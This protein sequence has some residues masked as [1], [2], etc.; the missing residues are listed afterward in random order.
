MLAQRMMMSI[1]KG[2]LWTVKYEADALPQNSTPAWSI[3]SGGTVPTASVTGGELTIVSTAGGGWLNY[4]ITQPSIDAT[5]THQ[6]KA[7][8]KVT[9]GSATF[10][11]SLEIDDG[12]RS[13]NLTFRYDGTIQYNNASASPTVLVTGKSFT[14]Y[15]EII[16]EL[17]QANGARVY[18]NGT[19]LGSAAYTDLYAVTTKQA[20]FGASNIATAV[21]DYVYY[22]PSV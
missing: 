14:A 17:S 19:L 8:A 3:S 7:K 5:K 4:F 13:A 22:A 1:Q 18:Q 16:V 9:S 6:L 10:G 21:F 20:S 11:F 2:L 12:I 15:S